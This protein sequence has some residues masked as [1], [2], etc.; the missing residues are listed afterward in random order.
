MLPVLLLFSALLCARS[1]HSHLRS[2]GVA[3]RG[4]RP[5]PTAAFPNLLGRP[6]GR[7]PATL[8]TA[9]PA[10]DGLPLS[11]VVGRVGIKAFRLFSLLLI[12]KSASR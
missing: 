12:V 7:Q 1:V 10:S 3:V 8:P 9:Q 4:I 11:M 6:P 5:N 2:P